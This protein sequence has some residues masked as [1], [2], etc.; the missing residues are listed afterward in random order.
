MSA[1]RV[2][3][4]ERKRSASLKMVLSDRTHGKNTLIA[5][6]AAMPGAANFF[7][8]LGAGAAGDPEA[9]IWADLQRV[10]FVPEGR[11]C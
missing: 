9:G 5:E 4:L 1:L 3:G 6:G 7:I 11:P 8:P 10:S 2:I